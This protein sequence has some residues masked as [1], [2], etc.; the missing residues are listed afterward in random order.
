MSHKA[1]PSHPSGFSGQ[2]PRPVSA[3]VAPRSHL[4]FLVTPELAEV[5]AFAESQGWLEKGYTQLLISWLELHYTTDG[6]ATVKVLKSTDVP[7]PVIDGRFYLPAIPAGTEVTFALRVGLAC[8]LPADT[9]GLRESGELWFNNRGA[10]Y[11]QTTV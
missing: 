9:Q 4:H 7:S 3:P 2:S 8:R 11:R 10:N 5:Q 1:P 6:W